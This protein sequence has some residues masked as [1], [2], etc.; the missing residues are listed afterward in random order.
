MT[1][2][3]IL[4]SPTWPDELTDDLQHADAFSV[5]SEMEVMLGGSP[6]SGS[7]TT[8]GI[9]KTPTSASQGASPAPVLTELP[10]PPASSPQAPR[11]GGAQPGA[12]AVGQPRASLQALAAARSHTA[13]ML[14]A[15][16][17]IATSRFTFTSLS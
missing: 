6:D 15:Q 9:K 13:S 11:A 3:Q 16:A 8:V 17:G 10:K 5:S 7:W 4:F 1:L 12:P 14:K 2:L